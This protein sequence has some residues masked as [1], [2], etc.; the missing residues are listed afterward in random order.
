MKGVQRWSFALHRR[1]LLSGLAA[2]A[3][4]AG[5]VS[6]QRTG[7]PAHPRLLVTAQDWQRLEARQAS[8]PDLKLLV[9]RLLARA[10]KDLALPPLERKLEGRRLLGISREFIRRVLLWSFAYRLTGQAPYLERARAEMLQVARFPDWNP[11]HFLDVAEMTTG[12]AVGYDWLFGA[13]PP[14][15]RV[16]LRRAIVDKGI[17]QVRN[18]HPTFKARNNW[19]QVCI[20]G[21]MLGA[22]AVADEEPELAAAIEKAARA[23]AFTALDAY[24]PDGVYPEGPSY[25]VYGT[26]YEVLLVAALRSALGTD[27]G[28]MG[29]PG[30]AR[31]AAFYAHAIGPTGKSFNFADGGEGQELASA[32]FF[33]ARELKSP[34]LIAAKRQMIRQNQGLGERFAPLAALWWPD[35]AEAAEPVLRFAGQGPQPVAIWRSSWTDPRALYFAIKGGG[36]RHNHAHMDGGSFVL[37]LDGVRWARDLGM[38]DYNSLESRGIDLW[39][40]AQASPRWRVFRLGNAAHNTLGIGDSLHNAAGMATLRMQGDNE[41]TIDLTP[42]FLPGQVQRASRAVRIEGQAVRLTDEVRGARPGTPVRWAMTTQA[43]IT[44]E[45][46]EAILRQDG[47]TLRIRF[48]GPSIALAVVDISAPRAE[49]DAPNPGTRQLVASGSVDPSGSWSLAVRFSRD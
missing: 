12:M 48:D 21:M 32:L 27:W 38:Q 24:R 45:G 34:H 41:A 36:A 28:L 44:L 40:M 23:D 2:S 31:S 4:L 20:G 35:D 18:G 19:G 3:A 46:G 49:F 11:S 42:V 6:A 8:D 15:E 14:Q 1:A 16:Q 37:D 33:L 7:M 25:W 30:L 39:S 17:A 9:T 5:E 22:L 13:L 10:Q 43:A 29:A 47:Q 26:S